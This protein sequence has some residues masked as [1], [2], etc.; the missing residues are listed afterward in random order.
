VPR[1]RYD[2]LVTLA[3]E[4]D[5]LFTSVQAR[6]AGFSDSVLVRMAQRGK[7]ERT[8][9][10]VY[11]IPYVPLNRFSQYR[12]AVLWVRAHRGPIQVALSHETALVVYGISDANPASIHLTVPN[13]ARLRRECPGAIVIHHADLAADE[14]TIVE[15][16]PV[17][18]VARTIDDLLQS[19][20][21]IDLGKQAIADARKEGFISADEAQ[22]LRGR[23]RQH[24][25]RLRGS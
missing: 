6:D 19:G 20:G 7:I 1:S 24:L 2:K 4:N 18:T 22:R 14:V 17:T 16:L 12:E 25:N 15:G 5:G 23:I 11:R 3:E 10:G 13:S 21:R 9:R 8:G